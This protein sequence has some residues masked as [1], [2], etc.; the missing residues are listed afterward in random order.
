ME[1]NVGLNAKNKWEDERE[2]KW[3]GGKLFILIFS[4]FFSFRILHTDLHISIHIKYIRFYSTTIIFYY[5][6][7]HINKRGESKWFILLQCLYDKASRNERRERGSGLEKGKEKKR[8]IP[9]KYK[10]PIL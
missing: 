1:K 5:P 6:A 9:V 8:R 3:K 7:I 2:K 10:M 4:S